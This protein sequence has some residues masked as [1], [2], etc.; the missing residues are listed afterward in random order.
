MTGDAAA[1]E[2]VLQAV[3]AR[4]EI[5]APGIAK[6]TADALVGNKGTTLATFMRTALAKHA[7]ADGGIANISPFSMGMAIESLKGEKLLGVFTQKFGSP[8]YMRGHMFVARA[9]TT[10]LE[11]QKDEIADA[12]WHT[13]DE[14]RRLVLNPFGRK[15]MDALARGRGLDLE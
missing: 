8:Y 12:Q 14:A 5:L 10:A 6:P 11:L 15:A 7:T 4:A 9:L 3:V 13:L 1:T 2:P